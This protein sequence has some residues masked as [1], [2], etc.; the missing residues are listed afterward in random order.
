[1]S[2][3]ILGVKP[4]YDLLLMLLTLRIEHRFRESKVSLFIVLLWSFFKSA[5]GIT[6]TSS[7]VVLV[8]VVMI[9]MLVVV[10]Y[11]RKTSMR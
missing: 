10:P 9:L 3:V 6:D 4:R 5:A 7:R 11:M 2:A 8:M 1:M